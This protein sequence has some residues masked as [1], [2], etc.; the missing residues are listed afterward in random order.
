[1]YLNVLEHIEK[2]N[3]ENHHI[4]FIKAVSDIRSYNYS[5]DI[6]MKI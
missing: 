3:D 1:M 4:D 2:D 5:I 6:K